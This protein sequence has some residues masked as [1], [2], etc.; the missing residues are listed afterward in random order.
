LTLPSRFSAIIF[1]CDGV[2]VDSE[3]LAM[4]VEI[5]ALAEIDLVYDD[6]EFRARF[7]GMS[8]T[9]FYDALEA[10]HRIRHGR[11][12]PD[13]FRQMCHGRY[14]AAWH[15]LAEVPGARDAV[16]RVSLPKAVASSSTRDG[17]ARKLRQT[18]LWP[19]FAPHIYSADHVARAKPAPDLFLYTADALGIAPARCLVLED[20]ANGIAAA[21][22]AG[23]TAWGFTGGGHMGET[24][25]VRLQAA[26]AERL[27]PDWPTAADVLCT[28]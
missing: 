15:R 28:L 22:A 12:L 24:C 4:E 27:L 11:D 26:G 9:A 18:N 1:D 10:D 13:G 3:V 6:S 19:L 7:L 5:K 20:S 23:M 21:R 25:G 2:L 14:Q 17:L 16:G 8:N